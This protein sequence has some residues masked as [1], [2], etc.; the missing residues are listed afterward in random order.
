MAGN[1]KTIGMTTGTGDDRV[2]ETDLAVQ[3]ERTRLQ[4][5]RARCRPWLRCPIDD[6]HAHAQQCQPQGQYQPRRTSS[7]DEEVDVASQ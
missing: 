7:D 5:K 1:L 6:P 2:G 4:G 3:L